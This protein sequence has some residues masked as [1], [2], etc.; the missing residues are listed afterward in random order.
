MQKNRSESYGSRCLRSAE[1]FGVEKG[2]LQSTCD[3][4]RGKKVVGDQLLRVVDTDI[5]IDCMY[6]LTK[7]KIKTRH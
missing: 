4:W 2:E 3:C 6:D 7:S 5:T 1:G